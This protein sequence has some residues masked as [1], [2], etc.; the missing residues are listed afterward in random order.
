MRPRF[1]LIAALAACQ[2]PREA[3]TPRDLPPIIPL[4]ASFQYGSRSWNYDSRIST[5]VEAGAAESYRLDITPN[6]AAIVAG[7]SAGLFYAMQTLQQLRDA[8]GPIRSIHV[9]DGPRF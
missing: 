2:S 8:G 4:P 6:G 5:K 1:L 9:E 7:D 3:V